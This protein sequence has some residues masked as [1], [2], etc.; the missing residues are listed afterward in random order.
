MEGYTRTI[1]DAKLGAVIICVT[2]GKLSEG[3]NF[4]D[5]LARAVIVVGMPY[6]NPNCPL[7]REKMAYLDRQFGNR[8]SYKSISP[9]RQHYEAL[10]MRAINQAIGRSVRHAKDYAAVFLVDRRF[11]RPNIQQ[12]LA[13]W[14]AYGLQCTLGTNVLK[15][16][17]GQAMK[18]LHEFFISAKKYTIQK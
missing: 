10:C 14:V 6:P 18:K 11:T 13:D 9:G 15:I 3:I 16:S 4:S 1:C 12:K 7:L 17:L 2:G 5:E 8:P